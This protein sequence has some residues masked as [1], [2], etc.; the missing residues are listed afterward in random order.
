MIPMEL[1]MANI[2]DCPLFEIGGGLPPDYFETCRLRDQMVGDECIAYRDPER[3][4]RLLLEKNRD[5]G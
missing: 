4:R 5:E 1:V 2:W 3:A